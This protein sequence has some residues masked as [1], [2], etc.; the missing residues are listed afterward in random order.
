MG[1]YIIKA[2]LITLDRQKNMTLNITHQY[3]KIWA[4]ISLSL[5]II[6]IVVLGQLNNLNIIYQNMKKWICLTCQCI[7]F[8]WMIF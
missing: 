3:F 4:G 5:I 7:F 6:K 1:D 2:E 8:V